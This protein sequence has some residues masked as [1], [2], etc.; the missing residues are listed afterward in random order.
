VYDIPSDRPG[1]GPHRIPDRDGRHDVRVEAGTRLAA[2]LGEAPEPVNSHHHQ[3]VAEPGG[4]LRVSARADDGL[5]EAVEGKG[6]CV[7]V[8]WHP[9]RMRGRHR[10]ALFGAFVS[11][12]AAHCSA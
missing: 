6:F 8:Q 3:C 5:I 4:S 7:G 1:A 12:C 9:E 11:A 2:A 10:G